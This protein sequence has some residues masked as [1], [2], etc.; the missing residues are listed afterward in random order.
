[1]DIDLCK[2]ITV[3][4]HMSLM[5]L[6]FLAKPYH[7]TTC[8]FNNSMISAWQPKYNPSCIWKY[9]KIKFLSIE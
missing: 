7:P 3:G 2:F 8:L 6:L 1:M 9:L 5:E 4:V